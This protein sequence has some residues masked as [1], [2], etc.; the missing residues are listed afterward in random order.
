MKSLLSVLLVCALAVGSMD[1]DACPRRTVRICSPIT[2]PPGS[3]VRMTLLPTCCNA[4]T[5]RSAIVDFPEPSM[6][7]NAMN[8]P[9]KKSGRAVARDFHS[10]VWLLAPATGRQRI[11]L[12]ELV[13]HLAYA[14]DLRGKLHRW[15]AVDYRRNCVLCFRDCR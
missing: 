4:A 3:R 1:A 8:T 2:V 13:L 10:A 5:S 9:G 12:R 6:P 15:P 14:G 7:S 11:S